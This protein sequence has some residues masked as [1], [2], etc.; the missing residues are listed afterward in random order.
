ML[1]AGE[2]PPC[3]E[4]R[5]LGDA[6][7]STA[8]VVTPED[9]L[10]RGAGRAAVDHRVATPAR[11][12]PG[13]PRLGHRA[14]DRR[15]P[16][17]PARARGRRPHP[18]RHLPRGGAAAAPRR[19]PAPR[20]ASWWPGTASRLTVAV[21]DPTDV[22]ALDDVRLHTGASE[23]TV[24]VATESQVRD[25]LTRVWS[26]SEDSTDVTT[27]FDEIDAGVPR[28]GGRRRRRRRRADRP[29]GQPGPRRRRAGRRERHPPRAAARDAAGPLPGR[30]RAARRHVR[31]AQR[32]GLRR[33]PAEDRLRPRHRRAPAAAGRPDPDHG[34][35]PARRRPGRRPCRPSTARRSSSGCSPAPTRSRRWTGWVSSPTSSRSSGTL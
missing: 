7:S 12:R 11:A 15:R 31:A 16:R 19:R 23:L 4:R 33:Q 20:H 5:R 25:H 2:L 6:A 26:L 28:G 8:G 10:S 9:E 22:V 30:R 1:E 34:R 14:P 35:R 29:A 27:Y 17:R 13:R 18:G 3:R 24:L 21:T 32:D